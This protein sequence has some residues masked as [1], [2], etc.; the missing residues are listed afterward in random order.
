LS[1]DENRQQVREGYA[2]VAVEQSS[3]CGGSTTHDESRR[4]GYSEAEL[5]TIPEGANMGLGCGNP[6]ALASLRAG[7]T[8]IDLGSGGGLDCLLAA[9]KVGK[10]GRIIGVDMTPEMLDKARR[11]ARLGN[12]SNVEFRL[13]EIENLPVA[14][15]SVDVVM[16][17]CVINLTTNKKRVFE[18]AFR[19]LKPGGRVMISDLVLSKELPPELRKRIDPTSCVTGATLKDKYLDTIKAAGFQDVNVMEEKQYYY[20]DLA[21]DPNSTVVVLNAKTSVAETK[22]VSELDE[23]TRRKARL[24]VENVSSISVSATKPR[25]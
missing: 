12:Y 17:N 11:N 19:V 25:R 1:E 13:G 5:G 23:E 2:K 16:S 6:V 8:V 7:E 22:K 20:E 10:S 4:V 21:S 15:N 14:D 9:K 24:Q 3:C 18:E